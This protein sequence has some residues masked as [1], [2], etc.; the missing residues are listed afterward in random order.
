MHLKISQSRL[1]ARIARARS[2]VKERVIYRLGSGGFDPSLPTPAPKG[3]SDCSGYISWVL[4]ISRFQGDKGK[5]WSRHIP[6]IETTAIYNDA[7]GVSRL[8]AKIKYPI[9]GCIAVYGDKGMKQGHVGL[10]TEVRD[11]K[12]FD[13]VDCNASLARKITGKA[14]GEGKRHAFYRKDAIF[15]ILVED[16]E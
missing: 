8:F 10:V 5:P 14:I 13:V 3:A 9:P 12:D 15:A 16:F 11:S 6:W 2:A 7:M 4:G 1:N